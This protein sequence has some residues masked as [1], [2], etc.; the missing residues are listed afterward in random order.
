M[1]DSTPSLMSLLVATPP[2]VDEVG[3]TRAPSLSPPQELVFGG[4]SCMQALR[5][6]IEAAAKTSVPVLI[7]GENGTG[8]ETI[9]R[10]IHA[11]S[12]RKGRFVKVAA[13]GG[14]LFGSV[15]SG[16]RE[17]SETGKLELAE[18]DTL[19]LDEI[20]DFDARIQEPLLELLCKGNKGAPGRPADPLDVRL[21]ST[22]S[23]DIAILAGNFR[24]DLFERISTLILRLPPLRERSADIPDLARYFVTMYSEKFNCHARRLSSRTIEDMQRHEWPGNIRQLENLMKWYV[25]CGCEKV[26]E[27]ELTR[28]ASAS[29]DTADVSL[30][31]RFSLKKI[32]RAVVREVE[33]RIILEILQA[34]HWNRR[35]T[36][37]ALNISYRAL[38]YKIKEAQLAP[39]AGE[40]FQKR[41]GS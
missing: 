26:I 24:Q 5:D 1:S 11:K 38:S 40:E 32:T 6:Q 31:G 20:T 2:P 14:E 37:R 12:P 10:L 18:G 7:Q 17:A 15:T 8:K 39:S 41:I 36:A 34:N 19:L 33:G 23:R 16:L 13:A 3:L 25:I 9:A 22:T 4:T 29:G 30:G 27:S 21:V 28:P 35:R